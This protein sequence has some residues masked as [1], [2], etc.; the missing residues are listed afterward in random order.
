[1]DGLLDCAVSSFETSEVRG[2]VEWLGEEVTDASSSCDDGFILIAKLIDAKD[3]DDVLELFVTLQEFLDATGDFVMLL[4]ND[5]WVKHV[6]R[7]FE[8]INGWVDA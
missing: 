8:W 3:G 2:N 1:M 7:G 5:G 6:R 4:S